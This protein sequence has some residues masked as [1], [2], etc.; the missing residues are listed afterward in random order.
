MN[1]NG[2]DYKDKDSIPFKLSFSGVLDILCPLVLR[3]LFI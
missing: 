1:C 2:L 3:G